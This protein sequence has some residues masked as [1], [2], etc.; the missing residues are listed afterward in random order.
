MK[1]SGVVSS[2]A[3]PSFLKTDI[4]RAIMNHDELISRI[5]D[6][7]DRRLSPERTRIAIRRHTNGTDADD[8]FLAACALL[9]LQQEYNDLLERD[10]VALN[11]CKDQLENEITDLRDEVDALRATIK[12]LRYSHD[13]PEDRIHA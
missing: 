8:L 13:D 7:L 11:R 2:E 12:N 6:V 5:G 4:T 10:L 1:S 3:T 9:R